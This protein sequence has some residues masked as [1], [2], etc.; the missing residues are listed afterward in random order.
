MDTNPTQTHP[1][2]SLTPRQNYLRVATFKR[3]DRI[4]NFEG[5]GNERNLSR[6]RR[7]GMP[8]D[9]TV[10]ETFNLDPVPTLI[11]SINYGPIPGIS[12]RIRERIPERDGFNITVTPWGRAGAWPTPE[13]RRERQWA[14]SAHTVI[15]GAFEDPSDW[16]LMKDQFDPD[17]PGRFGPHPRT[18]ESWE[19]LT[20]RLRDAANVPLILEVPSVGSL[21]FQMG[22]EN[23]GYIL[24]DAPETVT[25]ILRTQ[26]DLALEL[27]ERAWA[28][29]RFDMIWFWEDLAY[30]NGPILSPEH[31]DTIAAEPYRRLSDWFRKKGGE[32]VAVDS[33]GDVRR[34]IPSWLRAGV[35]HIWPLEPFAGMDVVA[36][37]REYGQ[38]FSMRG[39]ID[40]FCVTRGKEGIVR[41]LDR[42][43]PVVQDGGYIPHLDHMIPD[44][45]FEIYAY[46]IEQKTRMLASV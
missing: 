18:K 43:F 2:R 39:G 30:R 34:L 22:V 46:Y 41:E 12:E 32:L 25:S 36:L 38:A 20:G 45:S 7:E 6:W 28:T 16:E 26:A 33:D 37:R 31:W 42:I 5:G 21:S 44:C 10:Q 1:A 23:F 17:A 15:R 9:Q 14:E 4:P 35:N 29:S 19:A 8:Q 40:K 13:K 3:P 11:R 24:Y 27:L